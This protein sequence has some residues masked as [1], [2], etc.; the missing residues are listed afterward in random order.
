MRFALPKTKGGRLDRSKA[1]RFNTVVFVRASDKL[2]ID[3]DPADYFKTRSLPAR[4]Q[5]LARLQQGLLREKSQAGRNHVEP[6]RH[7]RAGPI[8]RAGEEV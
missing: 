7:I 3:T 8:R 6:D 1:L 2:P 5:H 4:H